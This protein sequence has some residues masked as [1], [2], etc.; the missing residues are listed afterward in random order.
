MS[1]VTLGNSLRPYCLTRR[2]RAVFSAR[3]S[4]TGHCVDL[5]RKYDFEN[6][7]CT[8]LLPSAARPPVFAVRAFNVEVSRIRDS[9]SES[10][11][12][13]M[14]LQFWKDTVDALFSKSA[15]PPRHPVALALQQAVRT[16]RISRGWLHRLVSARSQ[17]ISESAPFPTVRSMEEYA[18]NAFTPVNYLTL[19]CVSTDRSVTSSHLQLCSRLGRAQ[20][21]TSLL[22]SVG[23][24]CRRRSRPVVHLPT[25]VMKEYNVSAG[26]LCGGEESQAVRD[27]VY[28]VASSAHRH[29]THVRDNFDQIPRH[30][31]APFLPAVCV[32][33]YLARLQ[34]AHFNVFDR[35]LT[36]R[37]GW[38]PLAL[39]WH[40]LLK[41]I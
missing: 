28:T 9:V 27:V 3:Q 40:A 34:R 15:Q 32:R 8:L 33:R 13:S 21:V 25:E 22:R 39:G 31:R 37:D 14:R 29:L 38:L 2:A 4:S 36:H 24:L 19:Q 11:T 26:R 10:S 5:V 17:I 20:G 6:Y 41:S 1:S 16:H 7:L 23:P 12:A 35:S 30:L 18:V